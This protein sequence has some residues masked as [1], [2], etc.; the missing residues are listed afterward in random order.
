MYTG[1]PGNSSSSSSSNKDRKSYNICQ[2]GSRSIYIFPSRAAAM[3]AGAPGQQQ[4]QL[5]QRSS[6]AAAWTGRVSNLCQVGCRSIH[7]PGSSHAHSSTCWHQQ[8]A[9]PTSATAA[10]F[11]DGAGGLINSVGVCI[12]KTRPACTGS[13]TGSQQQQQ[14]RHQAY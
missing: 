7:P 8:A 10:A 6:S 14:Q 1:A 5:L 11:Q 13:S 3:Y 12:L 4:Q 2:V 9:A